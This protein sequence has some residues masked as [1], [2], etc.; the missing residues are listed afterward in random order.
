MKEIYKEGGRK[1]AFLNV[2]PLG[3]VPLGRLLANGTGSCLEEI[4]V[5]GKLHNTALSVLLQKIEKQFKG[6]K[7][8]LI[9]FYRLETDLIGH[10]SKYGT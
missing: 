6:F 7:Y 5:L 4:L 2:G 9:D 8:S 1:F 10:P 3:C